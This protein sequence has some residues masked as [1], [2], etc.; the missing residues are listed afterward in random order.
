VID[1]AMC[2]QEAVE[3]PRI[4]TQG[5]E[6]EVEEAIPPVVREA[7]AT[8]GHDLLEVTA[9]A[10]GMNGIMFDAETQTMIGAAC[11]RA[12]GSPAAL[13]GGPARPGVRFRTTVR[14]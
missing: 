11:W 12:D 4:W 3:A 14:R 1:H 7:L 10:G 6:L 5:Q 13:G 2:L 9:V 8:R